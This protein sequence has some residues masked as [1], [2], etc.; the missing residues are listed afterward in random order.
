MDLSN[1]RLSSLHIRW[2]DHYPTFG[3]LGLGAGQ[4]ADER[5]QDTREDYV[6]NLRIVGNI[7]QNASI[8]M[9]LY[10]NIMPCEQRCVASPLFWFVAQRCLAHE[11]MVAI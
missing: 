10:F 4:Q 5:A 8:P 1:L 9:W 3:R 11:L 6:R 7:T 2:P